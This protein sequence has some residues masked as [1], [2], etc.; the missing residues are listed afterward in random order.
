[1]AKEAIKAGLKT[2]ISDLTEGDCE[3]VTTVLVAKAL[4]E[5]DEV[6]R[7]IVAKAAN[8]LG[9]GIASFLNLFDPDIVVIGGGTSNIGEPLFGPI[10]EIVKK[11]AMKAIWEKVDIVPAKCGGD[12]GVLGA[13]SLVFSEGHID[14]ETISA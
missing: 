11:R 12:V 5:G 4:S 10:R 6:A 14:E 2:R 3:K 1:M 7:E 13:L 8:W 9:I